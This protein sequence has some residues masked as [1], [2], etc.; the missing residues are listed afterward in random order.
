MIGRFKALGIQPL[1][2]H[3]AQKYHWSPEE[4]QRTSRVLEDLLRDLAAAVKPGQY[5]V[6]ESFTRADLTVASMLATVFGH[7]PDDLFALDAGM[8]PM[9]GLPSQDDPAIAPL[10]GWRDELYR[11]HRGER[12]TPAA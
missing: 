7:P 6:G 3:F 9:F 10:R 5:L 12:V 11:R 2:D 8:R 4:E 1:G